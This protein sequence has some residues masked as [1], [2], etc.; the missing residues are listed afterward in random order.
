M[1][2]FLRYLCV[3][4]IAGFAAQG[5]SADK[6]K[7]QEH[8]KLALVLALDSSSSVDPAEYEFQLKGLAAAL[9]DQQVKKMIADQGGV[10]LMAFEWSGRFN[11]E[12][13]VD[14]RYLTSELE[15]AEFALALASHKRVRS[16][17]PTAMGYALGYAA[18]LFR[19]LP[20]QCLRQ[21]VDVSGDGVHNDGFNPQIAY[22]T[23]EFDAIA[24]NGLVIKGADPD[25][26]QYYRENVVHGPGAFLI[27]ANNFNDYGEAIKQKLLREIG[28]QNLSQLE[29]Q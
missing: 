21:V 12:V 13:I 23:F 1:T 25:P 3:L 16:D 2:G 26:E 17:Y 29:I 6:A 7:A 8:C 18:G 10:N 5:F 27:V 24:V 28:P 14:W 20:Y 15:V 11:Q 9:L 19:R 22:R 4:I